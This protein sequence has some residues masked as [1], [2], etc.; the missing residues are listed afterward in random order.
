[1]YQCQNEHIKVKHQGHERGNIRLILLTV[2][3]TQKADLCE[4]ASKI[5]Y[6]ISPYHVLNKRER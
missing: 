4:F 2:E 3:L 1:M 5:V 6:R